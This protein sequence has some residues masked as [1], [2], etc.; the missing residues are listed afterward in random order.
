MVSYLEKGNKKN[1]PVSTEVGIDVHKDE[2]V[3]R[4]FRH[5]RSF[6]TG[7]RRKSIFNMSKT[8]NFLQACAH[9]IEAR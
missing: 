9:K 7:V 6:L 4:N 3:S 1:V 2:R 5:V 8:E